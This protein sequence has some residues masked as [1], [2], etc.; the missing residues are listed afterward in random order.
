[1]G[2]FSTRRTVGRIA[3]AAALLGLIGFVFISWRPA[4]APIERPDPAMFSPELVA[5]GEALAAEAHCA[6]CHTAP[7]GQ[8]FAG[9]YGV[10]TPFGVIYGNNITPD[11]KTGIGRWSLTAF[12]RAMHEGVARDGSHLFP[13][14]PYTAYT[15]LS[16][17]DVKS[18]Y[19]FLMTR[20][21]VSATVPKNTVWFPLNL[22]LFQGG[23]KILFFKSE[24]YRPDP[25]KSAEW[26]RGAYLA[27]AV[28]DCG[29]CHPPAMLS[30]A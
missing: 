4:I 25:S 5:A 30:G 1:M 9:G 22:R 8:A 28:S 27:K 16:D 14:F 19:A 10:N 21:P 29:G 23:W 11:P 24:R 15:K 7:G 18:L 12:E 3:V 20:P 13:A 6:S 17:Q 2:T 26:N